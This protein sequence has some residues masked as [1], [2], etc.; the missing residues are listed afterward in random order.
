MKYLEKKTKGYPDQ[1][2]KSRL[3]TLKKEAKRKLKENSG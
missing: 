2:E 1:Q 3:L